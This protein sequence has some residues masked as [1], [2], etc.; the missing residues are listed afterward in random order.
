MVFDKTTNALIQREEVTGDG[1]VTFTNIPLTGEKRIVVIANGKDLPNVP[2]FMTGDTDYTALAAGY[3]SLEEQVQDEYW[4]LL[5]GDVTSGFLMTGEWDGSEDGLGTG[6]EDFLLAEGDNNVT[7]NVE[8]VVAKIELG[9]I[10]FSDEI[11][12]G[13][14]ANFNIDGFGIQQAISHSFVNTG[15]IDNTGMQAMLAGLDTPVTMRYYGVYDDGEG[16]STSYVPGDGALDVGV[17]GLLGIPAA[18]DY[19]LS[20]V[21]TGVLSD[22]VL[23]LLGEAEPE[24]SITDPIGMLVHAV[25]SFLDLGF[26]GDLASFITEDVV[27][28]VLNV[29]LNTLGVITEDLLIEV[30]GFWY[31]LPNNTG[32]DHTTTLTIQGTYEGNQYYYPIP[33]NI[34]T[35]GDFD[36]AT[37]TTD[38]TRIQRN[39]H[40]VINVRFNDLIGSPN[41]DVKKGVANITATIVAKPWT[42]INQNTEW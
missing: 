9:E 40:Y 24:I 42:E 18:S 41:P 35:E 30:G 6:D 31:V 32:V 37:D 39:T 17:L 2:N 38:G 36:D 29:S 27:T 21:L 14:I 34:T 1:I 33:V 3:T 7:I 16:G 4:T 25:I 22:L 15:A 23:G 5:G 28:P 13:Q 19:D 12:L 8:K 10:S 20:G 11:T 26:V